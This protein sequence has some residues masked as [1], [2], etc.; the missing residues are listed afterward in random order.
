MNWAPTHNVS[1]KGPSGRFINK[2]VLVDSGAFMSVIDHNTGTSLGFISSQKDTQQ[3]YITDTG[4]GGYVKRDM[5]VKIGNKPS[6]S[7][8]VAWLNSSAPPMPQP[9]LG[10][11]GVFKHFAVTFD[12]ANHKVHFKEP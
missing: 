10:R 4:G 5:I 9:I 11:R 6:F 2:R 8:P 3:K 1:M 7:A 12:T